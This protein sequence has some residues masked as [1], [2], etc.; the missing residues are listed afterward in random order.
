[1]SSSFDKVVQL[2]QLLAERFGQSNMV[3]ESI[4]PTGLPVLDELGIPKAAL[5]EIVSCPASGPG[6]ALLL[7][8]LLHAA[9]RKGERIALIDGKRAFAPSGLPQE[10]LNR[11]LWSRC[12]HAQDAVKAA[13]LAVRDGNVPLVILLLTLNPATELRRVPAT[14]WQRLQMLAEKSAVTLLVFT[15]Q[16]QIGCA[17]LRL[18]VGG[19]FPLEQLHICRD[20]LLPSL[21]VRV[22]R[23]RIGPG[24]RADEELRRASC[25]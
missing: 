17:K 7:Y 24:R 8:G 13:D 1:M 23:R 25:A 19:A 21:L 4:F 14:A 11:L 6:G 22:E 12:R 20:E 10:E 15:P 3:E 18:S 16:A 5:T 9:V 2:R